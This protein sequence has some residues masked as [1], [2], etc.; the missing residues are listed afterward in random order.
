MCVLEKEIPIQVK[1]EPVEIKELI[2]EPEKTK[3]R[4]KKNI[5]LPPV[6]NMVSS[7]FLFFILFQFLSLALIFKCILC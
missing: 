3:S 1:Q 5:P 7:F 6:S 2:P 4:Y